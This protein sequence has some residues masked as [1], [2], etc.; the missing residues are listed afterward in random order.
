MIP[1]KPYTHLKHQKLDGSILDAEDFRAV[2][3]PLGERLMVPTG[4]RALPS[5]CTME[6]AV[7][8]SSVPAV[9]ALLGVATVA[10]DTEMRGEKQREI[11]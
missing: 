10:E 8:P 7:C 6:P 5:D 1:T 2:A 11:F 9:R 3:E 4:T